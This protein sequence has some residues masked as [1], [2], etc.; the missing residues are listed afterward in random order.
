MQLALSTS[1]LAAGAFLILLF[2]L[3]TSPRTFLRKLKAR[4]FH[5]SAPSREHLGGGPFQR[6]TRDPRPI[7]RP[8]LLNIETSDGSGQ[9]CHPDVAHLP[10]GFGPEK[11]PYWM[12][13]TPYPYQDCRLENP[14]IFA[15]HDG[16]SWVIPSGAKN[17]LVRPPSGAQDHNSDPDILFHDGKLWL[18][19]RETLRGA[20]PHRNSIRLMKSADGVRW[21][22]PIE[23]LAENEG[24]YLMSPAV[25]YDRHVFAMWT[26]EL[27]AGLMTLVRRSS[28]D[29]VSWDAPCPCSISGLPEGRLVWHID[30]TREHGR[31]SAL[32]VTCTGLGGTG[33][34]LHYAYSHDDGRT[35]CASNFLF[36]QAYEFESNVQYRGTMCRIADEPPEY[37]LWYSAASR[38]NVFSIAH[39]RVVRTQEN[40]LIPVERASPCVRELANVNAL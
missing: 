39:L 22:P 3:D 9:A 2:V 29:G 21:T 32:L 14:E 38:S 10:G 35:W 37:A 26:I 16:L 40:T 6:I 25:I 19:F 23:I 7:H 5:V 31:L 1:L 15:S 30:V 28:A 33:S 36:E 20:Q 11:W 12:A 8:L 24:A 17:P 4:L 13:C 34:R 27:R 18:F